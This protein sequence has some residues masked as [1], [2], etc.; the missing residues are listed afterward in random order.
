MNNFLETLKKL[1]PARLSIMGAVLLGLLIFFIYI[2]M[3]VSGPK[4][5]MLYKDLPPEDSASISA[6]LEE[7]KIPYEVSSDGTTIKVS[8]KDIGRA[9]VL[10]SQAGL[11]NGG[12]M[13]YE[14]FDKQS[15]FGTTSFVQNINQV[16]ALEGELGRTIT[17]LETVRSAR[18]HLVLPQR[19]LFQRESRPASASV[20][21][22]L[23]GGSVLDREQILGIQSLIASAVP[24]LK[25]KNVSIVDSEGVL[26]ASGSE[27]DVTL[28]SNK[29]EE[30]K[31]SYEQHM[32]RVIEDLVG[33]TVGYGNVRANVVADLNFDRLSENQ[34]IY[35]PEG[36]VV[37]STQTI[38]DKSS[39]TEASSNSVSVQ[40]NI[41]GGNADLLNGSSPSSNAA[42]TEETT[43]FEISKTIRSLVR[44]TGE[45]KKLSVAVLID[46]TYD[47]D[48]EGKK[49]Y[50]PRTEDEI[51][52]L[53]ALVS[54]A[55]GYEE[56]RGD[57][58]EVINMQ[59]ADV[60]TTLEDDGTK[61][62]GFDRAD[63]LDAA[64]VLTVAVMIILVVLLV[65]Q[66][67]VGRLLSTEESSDMDGE[68]HPM[69]DPSGLLTTS[70]GQNPSLMP[71]GMGGQQSLP[72]G[73]ASDFMIS[74]SDDDNA[75]I[76]V[77]K[78]EGRVKAS[79]LKKVEDIISAYP[80]ETVSVLRGWM[81]QENT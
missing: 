46:G 64:E 43:N 45:V 5:K 53:T 63:L 78:V 13:G 30:A 71:P 44:E 21:I 14:L 32:T 58:L 79:T 36:Q 52:N 76:D 3:Q 27:D 81:S 57:K 56:S 65:L 11:A 42:R 39:E 25:A 62:L 54:S 10:I 29:A 69:L 23:R 17:A 15:S 34:E 2:S 8:D 31:H 9:R 55:I 47:T 72:H 73:S 16:R 75:M 61:I 28:L 7:T 33:R 51:K 49:T 80:E 24:G 20:F 60:S 37:R 35:D 12:S 59:F 50:K 6:K 19:E 41:P 22:K 40:N 67:M 74:Q 48:E 26:L 66:P 68:G 18:V 77:Q 70:H 38:E 4:M 1:G